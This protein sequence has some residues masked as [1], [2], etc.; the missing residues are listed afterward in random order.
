MLILE[1]EDLISKWKKIAG[2]R[3]GGAY[4]TTLCVVGDDIEKGIRHAN[5]IISNYDFDNGKTVK[6]QCIELKAILKKAAERFDGPDKEGYVAGAI[7]QIAVEIG[8]LY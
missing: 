7:G 6:E 1:I 2:Q 5:N 4:T 8:E 3:K